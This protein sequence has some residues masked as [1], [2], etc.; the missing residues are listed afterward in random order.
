M[1]I[2]THDP[3]P[4][5]PGSLTSSPTAAAA[6]AAAAVTSLSSR[7][8]PEDKSHLCL[9][10]ADSVPPPCYSDCMRLGLQEDQ[11]SNSCQ[12]AAAA[13]A[14]AAA[15]TAEVVLGVNNSPGV[16]GEKHK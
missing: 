11:G 9:A 15:A 5:Y 10:D 1:G 3:P 6:A 8:I 16:S 4:P 14:P 7:R 2:R 12:D 13:A